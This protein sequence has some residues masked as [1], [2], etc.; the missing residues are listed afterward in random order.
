MDDRS[1]RLGRLLGTT[2]AATVDDREV[3]GGRKA[4]A[5]ISVARECSGWRKKLRVIYREN[6]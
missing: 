6:L 2:H 1:P 5:G 3:V 4:I